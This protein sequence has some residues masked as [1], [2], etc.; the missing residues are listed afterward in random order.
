MTKFLKRLTG[1]LAIVLPA[2]ALATTPV[3]AATH[4]KAKH[5]VSVHK[6]SHKSHKK[7][8]TPTVS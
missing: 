7:I 3:M 1:T 6:I 5:H 4:H 8:A 2:V